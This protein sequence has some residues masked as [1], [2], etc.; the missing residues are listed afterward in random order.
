MFRDLKAL[1]RLRRSVG[2][3]LPVPRRSI[4]LFVGGAF[5][6]ELPLL[7]TAEV[8]LSLEMVHTRSSVDPDDLVPGIRHVGRRTM[9]RD[10]GDRERREGEREDYSDPAYHGTLLVSARPAAAATGT[11]LLLFG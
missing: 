2:W 3:S 8:A 10:L 5:T 11:E 9:I 1:D 6:D 7:C 4:A